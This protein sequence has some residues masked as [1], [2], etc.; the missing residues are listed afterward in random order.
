MFLIFSISILA[1]HFDARSEIFQ[2]TDK[3]QVAELAEITL[4]ENP[5]NTKAY[6]TVMRSPKY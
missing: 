5:I 4:S 1:L 3:D 6:A 2:L